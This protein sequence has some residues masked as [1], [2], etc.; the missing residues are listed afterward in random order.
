MTFIPLSLVKTIMRN[1]YRVR[2]LLLGQTTFATSVLKIRSAISYMS[3]CLR[4]M[5]TNEW[6]SRNSNESPLHFNSFNKAADDE[7]ENV[8]QKQQP[9]VQ[10]TEYYLY[11]HNSD[12]T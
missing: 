4:F 11:L 12:D 10:S 1:A 6:T 9:P 5:D 7:C 2:R 8:R 3:V